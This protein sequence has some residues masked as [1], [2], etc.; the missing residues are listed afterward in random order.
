MF[1]RPVP[2]VPPPRA[3]VRVVTAVLRDNKSQND[4]PVPNA[5]PK[6]NHQEEPIPETEQIGNGERQHVYPFETEGGIPN[7]SEGEGRD[8]EGQF[9][10]QEDGDP[11]R[12][13]DLRHHRRMSHRRK[14]RIVGTI[15]CLIL[16]AAVVGF[17]SISCTAMKGLLCVCVFFSFLNVATFWYR[18]MVH[19]K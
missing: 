13:R 4:I 1:S 8:V 17:F 12:L 9:Q 11:D 6:P 2:D 19:E 15:G 10:L 5:Q 7:G 3:F 16:V 14:T 18:G